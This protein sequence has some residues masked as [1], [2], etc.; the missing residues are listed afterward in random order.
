MYYLGIDVSKSVSPLVIL[1]DGGERFTKAFSLPND[2]LNFQK[3]LER[4]KGLNLSKE[5][6]L[7]RIE[8]TGIW[9]E[10]LYSFLT[11]AG[12]KVIILNPHQTNKFREALRKKAKTDDIDAYYLGW[13]VALQRI[14]PFL[15]A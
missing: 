3:L 4:L 12:Y 11:E 2:K 14:R 13:L 7:I 10:N 1:D 15:C 6:L 5:N 9:W 8:T